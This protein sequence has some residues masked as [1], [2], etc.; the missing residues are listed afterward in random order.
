M[1]ETKN[2]L[3]K[4]IIKGRTVTYYLTSEDDLNN[5]Q[6]NS[7]LGDIFFSIASIFVGG[8]VSVCL[9]IIT[10]TNTKEI[11]E[12]LNSWKIIFIMIVIV[13]VCLSILFYY[14]SFNTIKKIKNSGAIESFKQ[15]SNIETP[16]DLKIDNGNDQ[17][18][19]KLEII[20]AEYW[21]NNKRIDVT[22]ILKKRIEN[23]RLA[24]I[25]SNDL[26]GDPEPGVVKVLT[27]EY[28]YQNITIKKD[29]PENASIELP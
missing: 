12:N 13:F 7:I 18:D 1:N 2:D 5:I 15:S 28:K 26:N 25:A 4:T 23:N 29:F 8:I 22:E 24:F 16:N 9:T 6:S 11:I 17:N 20:K 3:I 27:I 10:S 19:S 14:K 21:T